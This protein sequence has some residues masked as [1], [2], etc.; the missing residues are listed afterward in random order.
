MRIILSAAI[1][2]DGYLDDAVKGERLILSSPEDWRAIYAL[3]AECDAILV[4][5]GTLREDNPALIIRDPALREKRE[6]EGRSPDI[7]KVAVSGSGRLDPNL[8]FFTEGDGEKVIFTMG[9]VSNEI[10]ELATVISRP[11]LTA[12]IILNQL[13]KMGVGTLVVEGGS[14][15]LSMFLKDKNWDEFRLGVAPIFVGDERAPRLVLDGEYPPMTLVKTEQ[16]GQTAVL[17][18]I[19][20]SQ[21]R[22]DC[23]Y[24]SRALHNSLQSEPSDTCYRVGA[25]VLTRDGQEFDGYTHETGPSDHAEEEAIAKAVEAKADLKGATIY[26]TI[27]PCS[28]RSSKPEPCADLIIRHGFARVVY[29]LR[30]PDRFVR[31]EATQRLAEAGIEV[32]ELDAFAADVIRVNSHLLQ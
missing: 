18:F 32:Y 29:A 1:S 13:R 20:R 22:R 3:R 16:L 24:I 31:C 25:V 10:S 27:E 2:A 7:M 5:A 23:G 12:T 19:N 11:E 15:V 21:Y 26:T 9:T 8:K 6:A 28:R 17:H 4:G 14:V 30:E